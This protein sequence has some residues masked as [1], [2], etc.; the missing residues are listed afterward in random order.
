MKQFYTMM[1]GRKTSNYLG[2]FYFVRWKGIRNVLR[3]S[4]WR[5][6]F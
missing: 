5:E 6:K 4:K 3:S 1:Y 2:L